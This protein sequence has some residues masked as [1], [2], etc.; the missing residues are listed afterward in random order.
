M[1]TVTFETIDLAELATATGGYRDPAECHDPSPQQ[2]I[3]A[4]PER[5]D[6]K[7]PTYIC[8]PL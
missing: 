8:R 6:D 7:P 2:G 5:N 4:A 1:T 3:I